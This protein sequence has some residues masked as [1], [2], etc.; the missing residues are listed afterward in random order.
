MLNDLADAHRHYLLGRVAVARCFRRGITTHFYKAISSL[1]S[2]AIWTL[3]TWQSQTILLLHSGLRKIF[4]G[5]A[6]QQQTKTAA[7]EP[8][9]KNHLEKIDNKLHEHWNDDE[10]ENQNTQNS[11]V[12]SV[13]TGAHKLNP[14]VEL[15]GSPAVG[16]VRVERLV[17]GDES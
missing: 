16:R 9:L 17:G 4:P 10:D 13:S 2:A 7:C 11:C 8:P 5:L 3:R 15:T 14:N 1:P 12:R 6:Y